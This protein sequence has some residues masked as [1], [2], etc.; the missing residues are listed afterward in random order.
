MW[1]T[2]LH[3]ECSVL[4]DGFRAIKQQTSIS[5]RLYEKLTSTRWMSDSLIWNPQNDGHLDI[6][7]N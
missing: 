2:S 6:K 1:H 3:N 7:K 5:N 4:Y